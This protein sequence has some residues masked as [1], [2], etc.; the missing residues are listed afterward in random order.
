M[1]S[2]KEQMAAVI[3]PQIPRLIDQTRQQLMDTKYGG[4]MKFSCL[5]EFST[6]ENNKISD[7]VDKELRSKGARNPEPQKNLQILSAQ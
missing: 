6:Q 2:S 3:S 4:E 1:E 5:T 7:A